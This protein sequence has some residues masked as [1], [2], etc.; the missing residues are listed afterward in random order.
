MSEF[1]EFAIEIAKEAGNL[2]MK[3]YNSD[4]PLDLDYKKDNS[5]LTRADLES[6]K[7]IRDAIQKKFPNH[8][9]LGEEQG[10]TSKK[11]DYTWRKGWDTRACD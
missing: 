2:I 6:E 4:E 9:I 10:L 3:Y 11:S 7:L 8:S 1:L 5:I